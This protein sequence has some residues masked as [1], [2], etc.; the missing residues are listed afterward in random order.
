MTCAELQT[1][2]RP[3]Q[4]CSVYFWTLRQSTRILAGPSNETVTKECERSYFCVAS[5]EEVVLVQFGTSP[6]WIDGDTVAR[7]CSSFPLCREWKVVCCRLQFWSTGRVLFVCY[8]WAVSLNLPGYT[9]CPTSVLAETSWPWNIIHLIL[10]S[11][12]SLY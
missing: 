2:F 9:M 7:M 3:A 1:H 12:D 5:N 11:T 4:S 10:S 8:L 6:T